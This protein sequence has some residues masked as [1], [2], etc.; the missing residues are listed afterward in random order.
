VV[1]DGI[2]CMV[3]A[4]AI[5]STTFRKADTHEMMT[6]PNTTLATKSIVNT[7]RSQEY[8]QTFL[9]TLP[10]VTSHESLG[11]I[12][13]LMSQFALMNRKFL[14]RVVEWYLIST[15]SSHMEIVFKFR[16]KSNSDYLFRSRSKRTSE[17][18]YPLSYSDND[19]L[20]P[21][22]DRSLIERCPTYRRSRRCCQSSLIQYCANFVRS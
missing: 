15:T 5:L 10:A 14:Y 20:I 1:I 18:S 7:S 6:I 4:I 2:N 16:Y 3:T 11:R 19:L 9:L 12:G 17:V 8:L 22:L 13:E 21:R